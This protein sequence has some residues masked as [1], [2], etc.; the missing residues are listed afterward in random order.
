MFLKFL[1]NNFKEGLLTFFKLQL[2]YIIPALLFSACDMNR[3]TVYSK[4]LA[5]STNVSNSDEPNRYFALLGPISGANVN[6]IDIDKKITIYTTKTKTYNSQLS[7]LT[8]GKYDVGSFE[9]DINSSLD[10]RTW[11]KIE[12]DSGID[13][14]SN[15]DGIVTN[16]FI[17]LNGKMKAYCRVDDLRSSSVIVNIFTTIFSISELI[18]F[19]PHPS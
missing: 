12:I 13:V 14:D 6:I 18:S 15:D 16:S 4:Q 1:V 19:S 7:S 5:S 10:G 9:V 11:V 8:W 3:H 17:E 2:I